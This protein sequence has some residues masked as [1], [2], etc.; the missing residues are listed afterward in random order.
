MKKI[1]SVVLAIC[2]LACGAVTAIPAGAA[3]VEIKDD[4]TLIAPFASDVLRSWSPVLTRNNYGASI[5]LTAR[6]TGTV[7][8]ELH[9]RNGYITEFS[10][11]FTNVASIAPTTSRTTAAG[12]YK[13]V[14][15]ITISGHGTTTR[16]SSWMRI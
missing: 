15:H 9:N 14:I 2:M 6:F 3:E 10:Q 16:E 7:T 13:I 5:S 1:F 8:V 11:S 12:E 4:V